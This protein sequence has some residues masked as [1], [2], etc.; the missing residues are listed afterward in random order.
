MKAVRERRIVCLP[1]FKIG[2][3]LM[4]GSVAA[5]YGNGEDRRRN[6]FREK[7]IELTFEH[8]KFEEDT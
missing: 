3:L 6:R 7:D 8:N 4:Q 1:G 5:N 2:Q